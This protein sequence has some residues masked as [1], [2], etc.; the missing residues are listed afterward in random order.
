[1]IDPEVLLEYLCRYE[2]VPPD[3]RADLLV[4]LGEV[5]HARETIGR[6]LALADRY[7]READRIEAGGGDAPDMVW[8]LR[9]QA[10]QIRAAVKGAE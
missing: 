4:A 3:V 1:M 7:D 9:N 2:D 6:M 5:I 10:L 8:D